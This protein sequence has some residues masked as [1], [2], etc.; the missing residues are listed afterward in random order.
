MI[1]RDYMKSKEEVFLDLA[2]IIQLEDSKKQKLL[3]FKIH[4]ALNRE[5][6]KNRLNL[7]EQ[8]IE[9]YDKFIKVH[10]NLEALFSI[11]KLDSIH[12]PEDVLNVLNPYMSSLKIEEM[13]TI[14]LNDRREVLNIQVIGKGS[15]KI[16]ASS[17]A[18]IFKGALDVGATGVIMAHNHPSGNRELSDGDLKMA[19]LIE[20]LGN[21][22]NVILVDS[23]VYTKNEVVSYAEEEVIKNL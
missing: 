9:L 7:N 10:R 20:T 14:Y 17:P 1:R 19:E 21:Y 11:E 3:S 15:E 18:Q 13:V 2:D 4:E 12:T 5:T 6:M 8:Q 22:L 23:L 16:V